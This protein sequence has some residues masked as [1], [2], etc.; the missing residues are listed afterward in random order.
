MFP[1]ELAKHKPEY[2]AKGKRS[3]VY[4]LKINNKIYATKVKKEDIS[5]KNTVNN[6][7]RF[8]K[9]LNKYKIGPRFKEKGKNYI[10]YEFIKGEFFKDWIK[11]AKKEN[12][13]KII[14]E[15]LKQCR[16]LDKLKI[17]K[18]EMHHPVKH[19]IINK[20][21]PVMIDFE[22]CY[23]TKKPKNV[24]QFCQLLLLKN[25]IEKTFIKTLKEYKKRET[26]ENF[27]KILKLI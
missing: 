23:Y 7:A 22:R 13:K 11:T 2:L 6:E 9:I 16:T 4:T 24:T 12:I 17:N 1:K 27:N 10:I 14:I 5:A 8:L 15:V 21:K 20:N 18:K 25:I 26:E 19:I 3:V